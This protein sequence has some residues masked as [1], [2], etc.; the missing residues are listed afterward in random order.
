[1]DVVGR[2]EELA[3]A[4]CRELLGRRQVG[5]LAF[6]TAAGLRIYP[7]NYVVRDDSIVFRTL[8]YGELA[9]HVV[10]AQVAF[11]VD[12]LDDEMRS[13]W[14]VLAVGTC[15]RVEEPGEVR[16][17]REESPPTPWAEGQRTLYFRLAWDEL[18]GRRV[19]PD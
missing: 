17:I 18:T 5:R 11:S 7:V 2:L 1:V 8:P 16:L 12:E 10:D 6:G 13:G 9:D 3:Q 14:H 4:E 19:H 15:R